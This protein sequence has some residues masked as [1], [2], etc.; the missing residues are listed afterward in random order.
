M[1]HVR[2]FQAVWISPTNTRGHRVK[3]TDHRSK[4]SV[5]ISVGMSDHETA[6]DVA[7]E[8]LQSK[9]IEVQSYG[10]ALL[11]YFLMTDNFE[12]QIK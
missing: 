6:K 12:N 5:I 7:I 2:I 1:N 3:I 10:E 11:G 8:F 9:G 4:K